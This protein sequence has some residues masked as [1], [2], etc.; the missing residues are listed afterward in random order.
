MLNNALNYLVD[1]PRRE[2]KKVEPFGRGQLDNRTKRVGFDET[3]ILGGRHIVFLD[4]PESEATGACPKGFI[5]VNG[6]CEPIDPD[7][8]LA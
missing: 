6:V 7:R 1:E 4:P 8:Y 2:L 3:L 5:N